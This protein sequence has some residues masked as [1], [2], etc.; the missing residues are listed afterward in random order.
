VLEYFKDA[1]EIKYD[2]ILPKLYTFPEFLWIVSF[3]WIDLKRL[4]VHFWVPGWNYVHT[5]H[6]DS[7]QIPKIE[8]SILNV[9]QANSQS[10]KL[11]GVTSYKHYIP[12][13]NHYELHVSEI[14]F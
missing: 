11:H 9:V 12:L 6:N 1:H 4:F 3:S 5:L 8:D 14:E 7:I 2:G 13:Y 10:T